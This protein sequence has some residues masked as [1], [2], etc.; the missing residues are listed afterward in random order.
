MCLQSPW[1]QKYYN[2]PTISSI[3]LKRCLLECYHFNVN[4]CHD[5]FSRC[6]NYSKL[7]GRSLSIPWCPFWKS[8]IFFWYLISWIMRPRANWGPNKFLRA[9]IKFTKMNKKHNFSP[10][11]SLAVSKEPKSHF[12][13]LSLLPQ[14]EYSLSRSRTSR[15]FSKFLTRITADKFQSTN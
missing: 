12:P 5:N 1:I 9:S 11:C 6:L 2:P 4:L 14:T 13:N 8:K 7:L 3:N 10:N 15:K